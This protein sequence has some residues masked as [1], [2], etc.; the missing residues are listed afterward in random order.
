M[1]NIVIYTTRVCPYCVKAK[2]LLTRKGIEFQEIDV[3]D[4][5]SLRVSMIAKA[6]GRRTVP[7]IFIGETHV[8]GCDDLYA[9]EA[10]GQLDALLC[11]VK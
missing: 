8:G 2:S 6:G 5:D 9:L 10:A 3:S 1:V 7:Q 4:D 11:S